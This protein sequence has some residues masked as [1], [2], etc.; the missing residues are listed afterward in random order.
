VDNID[1][2]LNPPDGFS[3]FLQ[4]YND[5]KL[6]NIM[7]ARVLAKKLEGTG[8]SVFT[9]HPGVIITEFARNMN[10]CFKC[11]MCCCSCCFRSVSEG[12][13]T[14]VYCATEEGLEKESGQYFANCRL[15]RIQNA[16]GTDDK[17]CD[18]L[19]AKGEELTKK[20]AQ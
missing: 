10:A 2:L 6:A 13:S 16:A 19:W 7:H 18:A 8:V 15:A 12:A 1:K 3:A 5:S 4:A 17:V 11:I 20:F 9:L 14:T